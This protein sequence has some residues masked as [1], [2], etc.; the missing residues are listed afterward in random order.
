MLVLTAVL[1]ALAAV[2][3]LTMAYIYFMKQR[4]P[5]F[6]LAVLHGVFAASALILLLWVVLRTGAGGWVSWALGLFVVAALAGFFLF[7]YHMR[8]KVLPGP[9]VV[10]HA[11]LA[12]TAFLLLLAGIAGF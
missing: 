6:A 7:S 3:G 10:V 9:G 12:V 11:A 2:G 8:G 1:F 5:P 4:N